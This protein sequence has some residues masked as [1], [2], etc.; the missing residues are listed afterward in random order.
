MTTTTTTRTTYGCPDWCDRTDHDADVVGPDNPPIHYGPDFGAVGVQG[1]AGRPREAIVH[2]AG[3]GQFC[4]DP[5]E[6]RRVAADM[7]R[8]AAWIENARCGRCGMKADALVHNATANGH[9]FA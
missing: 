3:E 7:V 5:A 9:D 4:S 8:A 1:G 6:L 2:L